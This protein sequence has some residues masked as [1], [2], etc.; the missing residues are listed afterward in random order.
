MTK[1]L[2]VILSL[3]VLATGAMA[4][5]E[6]KESEQ[7][8]NVRPSKRTIS[9]GDV[10]S[11]IKDIAHVVGI[12][13]NQL[14]GYGL[15]VGLDNTGDDQDF[16]NQSLRNLL[17]RYNITTDIDDIDPDNV[18]A[19]MVTAKLPPFA[20]EGARVDCT[21]SSIGDTES[22]QGGVLLLTEMK[23]IDGNVYALAQGPISIGGFV[24][25]AGGGGQQVQKNHPTVG[26]IPNGAIIEYPLE[27]SFVREG[28]FDLALIHPDFTTARNI[29]D[30]INK[31]FGVDA[32]RAVSPGIVQVSVTELA[33]MYPNP[34][35]LI[36]EVERVPV[37][38]DTRARVVINER[39][40]TIVAGHDVRISTVAVSHGPLTINIETQEFVSQPPPFSEGETVVTRDTRIGVSEAF[41]PFQVLEDRGATVQDLVDAFQALQGDLTPRDL[42]AIFSAL[43]EAGALKAELVIM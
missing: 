39:T 34:V 6:E 2:T 19:V 38:V 42:I 37:R 22:L 41:G 33:S 36:A 11:R 28:K 23:G 15:V 26:L 17:E 3:L 27:T 10:M 1:V 13:D 35:T 9:N 8:L 4:Q 21:V 12:R 43:K 30:S 20:T 14:T 31:F 16:T 40:G 25:R 29:Q 7:V 32:A 24:V 18:A 5:E